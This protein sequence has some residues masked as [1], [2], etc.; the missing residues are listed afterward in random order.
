MLELF[1]Y[2]DSNYSLESA[3]KFS[4]ISKHF[5]IVLDYL[6]GIISNSVE[7]TRSL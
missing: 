5:V 3:C 4:A 1:D 6:W 2:N 7:K